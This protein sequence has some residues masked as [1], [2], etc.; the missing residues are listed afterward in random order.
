MRNHYAVRP[1]VEAILKHPQLYYG[2]RMVKPPVVYLAG[3][4]RARRRGI[5]TEAWTW[6]SNQAGQQL[7]YPP[8]VAGWDDDALARHRLVPRTLE[9]RRPRA[10]GPPCSRVTT[11]RRSTR[12]SS[13]TARSRSGA[14][15][16]SRPPTKRALKSFA[17]HAIADADERWK[18]EQ[19]PPLIENALRAPDRH[20]PGPANELAMPHDCKEHSRSALLRKAVA[21]AGRRAARHRGGHAAAGRHG[22]RPPQLHRAHRSGSAIAVYGATSLT[23]RA[24]DHGIAQA[25]A[26]G[27]SDTVLVTVFLDGGIDS[28]SVLFP[29]GDPDYRRLRPKLALADSGLV[30]P[31]DTRLRWHPSAAAFHTLHARGQARSTSGRRVHERGPVALHVPPLLGGRRHR[32]AP[33]DW[34]A[35]P[36]PRPRREAPDNPLQGVSLDGELSPSL[37]TA[38]K[39]VAA[40]SG[41][42]RLLFWAPGVWGQVE[43][44]MLAAVGASGSSRGHDKALRGARAVTFQSHRLRQQLAPFNG[45][46]QPPVPYPKS[47]SGF[48]DQMAGLAAMLAAGLPLHCVAISANGGYDTHSDQAQDLSDNLELAS[49]TLLAFQRDLEARGLG[50]RVLTL[51]WSEFGRRAEENGSDGTDHGA[52]G[53]GLLMGS[54]VRGTMIGEFPGLRGGLDEDGNLKATVDY[55]T[56]Y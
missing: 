8:N 11:R 51:V 52:A 13:S 16:A 2:P 6:L 18:K 29:H 24:L 21:Q 22:P 56:I 7:F 47:D 43:D 41:A 55:R 31:E 49:K 40:L 36:L 48:P 50:N 20:L 9:R 38:K 42:G 19:Y 46:F 34:L 14:S 53:I 17:H 44:R 15:R 25:L 4:L 23:P 33:P 12:T 1:V 26:A 3:M 37:A 54:R 39:P 45:G 27:P 35:R 10:A 5:D 30:F 28:L 32:S